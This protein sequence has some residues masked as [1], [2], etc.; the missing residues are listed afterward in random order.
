LVVQADFEPEVDLWGARRR[1]KLFKR[2]FGK[3]LAIEWAGNPGSAE[4]VTAH[5]SKE[6]E[7]SLGSTNGH[8]GK[9]SR[10][11]KDGRDS[12]N[13]AKSRNGHAAKSRKK[14]PGVER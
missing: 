7:H 5:D 10:R 13:G 2:V 8:A 4:A 1:T 14:S 11:V 6:A 3:K 9:K 12:T